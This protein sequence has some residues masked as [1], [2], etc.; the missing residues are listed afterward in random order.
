MRALYKVAPG[1]GNMEL[2]EAPRP[3]PGPGQ[4]VIRVKA[5]GICGSDLHIRA[6]DIKIPMRPPMITGHEFSGVIDELGSGV[7]G[8]QVGERVTGEPSYSV[9]GVCPW[10][11]TGA[12]NLC[13]ERKVL[14]YWVDGAFAEY[15][16]VPADRLHR[17]PEN[18][19]FHEGALVE[20][21]AC[22]VHG[23]LEL[24]GIGA[25]ELVVVSGPGA[26]GLLAMQVARTCGAR[27][28]VVGTEADAHRLDVARSLGAD[29]AVEV[30]NGR[31]QDLVGELSDGVG[32]DVV[33]ECSGA[34]AAVD[35]GLDLV[36]RQ[37]RY[38]QIGLFGRPVTVDWERI[39]Y[40]E[41]R[42][43]GSFSQRWTA[44]RRALTLLERGAIRLKPLISD[45]LPLSAWEEGF[46]KAEEREGLKV[47]LEP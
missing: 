9:C 40:K 11:R 6:W 23:V 42:V 34:P 30:G 38:T 10:C 19:G 28:V 16:V 20:P 12:Y 1:P 46:R 5:A 8:W 26:I 33:L 22:C 14:G 43:T 36:R 24:T 4:V 17:L 13:P 3:T 32:A 45:V 47:I 29:Y 15:T 21:L 39:A 18:V 27:I 31:P 37:G 7:E 44:W 35:V 25:G 41:L 2:R